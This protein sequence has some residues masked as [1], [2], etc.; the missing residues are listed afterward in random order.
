LDNF[1]EAYSSW[2]ILGLLRNSLLFALAS[3][4]ITFVLGAS[5][6]WVVER[7]DIRRRPVSHLGAAV[8]RHS[9]IADR[10]WHGYS[11]FSPNIGLG[12]M[13]CSNRHSDCAM[14]R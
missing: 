4:V 13:P 6:A 8:V 7:T 3:A 1:V 11:F 9:G 12:V 10:R 2:R 5:V 14:R